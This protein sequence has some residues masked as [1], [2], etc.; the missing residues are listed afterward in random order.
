[1]KSPS[2]AA[3]LVL[4]LGALP[5]RATQVGSSGSIC[6]PQKA[7][8]SKISYSAQFGATNDS[9]SSTARVFC[10][11]TNLLTNPFNFVVVVRDR[12][13]NDNANVSCT[14]TITNFNTGAVIFTATQSTEGSSTATQNLGFFTGEDVSGGGATINCTIPPKVGS[15]ASNVVNVGVF[16]AG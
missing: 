4:A 9:T 8:V 3:V 12:N 14:L 15:A 16:E 1:M 13:P 11:V 7:D 2:M 10:P 6:N 5:A